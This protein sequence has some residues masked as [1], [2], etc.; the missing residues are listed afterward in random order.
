VTGDA[1]KLASILAI[2]LRA[3]ELIDIESRLDE[4]EGRADEIAVD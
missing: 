4:I 1:S 2:M 3:V